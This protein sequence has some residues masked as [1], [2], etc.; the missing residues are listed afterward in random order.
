MRMARGLLAVLLGGSVLA[1]ACGGEGD[2]FPEPVDIATCPPPAPAR[3]SDPLQAYR[4]IVYRETQKIEEMTRAFRA[5]YPN[6]TFYRRPEFRTDFAEYADRAICIAAGIGNLTPPRE[7]YMSEDANLDAMIQQLIDH[8][9]LGREAVRTRNV[10]Q[11]RE[12]NTWVEQK[13]DQV[14]AA[15]TIATVPR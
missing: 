8:T 14:R 6:G 9:L 10:S 12:W 11:Y 4:G 2:G 5:E 13:L 15:A 3:S 1:A 7:D